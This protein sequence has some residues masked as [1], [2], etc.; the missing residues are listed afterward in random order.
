M[1][2][3]ITISALSFAFCADMDR[4]Q[5][6]RQLTAYKEAYQGWLATYGKK[7]DTA[8]ICKLRTEKQY[9]QIRHTVLK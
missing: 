7:V 5:A 8:Y 6:E 4:F 9:R 2:L 1:M 3:S